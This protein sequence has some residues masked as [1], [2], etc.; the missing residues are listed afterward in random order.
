MKFHLFFI[1]FLLF[2]S[3]LTLS[4]N[5]PNSNSNGALQEALQKFQNDPELQNASWGFY[6][7]SVKTGKV[8]AQ[9]NAQKSLAPASSM[10]V[11][12]TATALEILGKDYTFETV[13]EYDG[14]VD[15][16][17]TLKGNVYIRGGGDPTLG[18]PRDDL[19]KSYE[20]VLQQ[21]VGAI[22]KV[23]IKSIEGYVV[24]DARFFEE[25]SVPP[26]WLWEDL[27]NYY[28]AGASGL[29]FHENQYFAYF[30]SE[31]KEGSNTQLT[32]ITPSIPNFK[33]VNRVTSGEKGS[34][35]NAYIFAAPYSNI[36]YIRGTIPPARQ[37]FRVKG[38][39]SNP[40]LFCAYQLQQELVK[41]GIEAGKGY[42]TVRI[43]EH[44]G[45]YVPLKRTFLTK[46]ISPPLSKIVYWTNKKSINLF[47][48]H[49]LK[50]LGKH[51]F[52]KGT[53]ENGVLLVEEYLKTCNVNTKGFFMEDGSGLSP[54]N[55]VTAQQ[56]GD[57]LYVYRNETNYPTFFE[58][59]SVA[60]NTSDDGGLKS[61]LQGTAAANKVFAKS[62]YIERVRSYTG[63]AQTASGD[64]IAFALMVNNYTCSNSDMRKKMGDLVEKLVD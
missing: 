3:N 56:F 43:L 37:G 19:G 28:G 45:K 15:A 59:L 63:Y 29:S 1:A 31:A 55:G 18:A 54:M 41:V 33:I 64:Q 57:L 4:P 62:G 58:S 61:F 11:I 27:G 22:R 52:G 42:S 20:E 5:L 35:D 50:A 38:S 25:E 32:K 48:E 21:W 34:G 26:S 36:A 10:K 39:I 49:L 23:G 7:K 13:L 44:E 14:Q 2:T 24:G 30:N 6:A 51:R 9:Y 60:G 17:G 12:T 46:I 8:V 16:S 47:A 53:R 40:A